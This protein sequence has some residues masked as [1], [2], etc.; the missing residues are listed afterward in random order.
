MIVYDN[1][2]STIQMN[3]G[4]T[5]LFAE[6][7][8]RL[9]QK[10]VSFTSIDYHEESL[11]ESPVVQRPRLLERYRKCLIPENLA[12]RGH[13]FHSTYYRNSN[14][15]QIPTIVTVH[16]FT[17]ERVLSGAKRIVHHIQKRQAILNA[18]QIICVS[19][20]TCDDLLHFIP[21]ARNKNITVIHNGVSE[22]Y[23]QLSNRQITNEVLFVG[24]RSR[25]K[26]FASLV[27]AL[28]ELPDLRLCCIGG[29]AFTR[30][31]VVFLERIIPGRYKHLGPLSNADLNAAYNNA[32]CLVYPSVYEG[33]GIPIVESMRAG[34]PVIATR[35]SS[36]PEVAGDAA[37]LLDQASPQ[38]I[39]LALKT[40]PSC[41]NELVAR[42][43]SRA[44]LFSWDKTFD[45]TL[46]IYR[47]FLDY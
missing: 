46:N 34:C 2:I 39:Y 30:R 26:N 23:H 11:S 22:S 5:V 17:Y 20:N 37:I 43:E 4:I 25:Y 19:E 24:Q 16:D 27:N 29:G 15:A 28:S 40:V 10:G 36:I 13:V 8:D 7:K 35:S 6:I 3:G 14:S 38:Q 18:D 42:G 21:E 44:K 9:R 47:K 33:F 31:E 41:R 45:A 1:I 32:Y 12:R